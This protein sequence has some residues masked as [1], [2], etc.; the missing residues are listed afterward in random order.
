MIYEILQSIDKDLRFH[1]V[2]L[3]VGKKNKN[4]MFDLVIP[5]EKDIDPKK[6]KEEII[7]RIKQQEPDLKPLITIDRSNII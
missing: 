7:Q 5:F 2:R 4:L 1:D 6:L 3:G